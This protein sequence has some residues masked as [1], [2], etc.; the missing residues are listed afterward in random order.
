MH[1]QY[2]R[3]GYDI[4]SDPYAEQ[5]ADEV[6]WWTRDDEVALSVY[7][8]G[9]HE[10]WFVTSALPAI[11]EAMLDASYSDAGSAFSEYARLTA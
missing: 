7:R 6:R 2:C 10:P 1:I 8:F 5:D 4:T 3:G 11:P 9:D